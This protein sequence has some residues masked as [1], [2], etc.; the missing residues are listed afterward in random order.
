MYHDILILYLNLR[1]KPWFREEKNCIKIM[2]LC[3]TWACY[4]NGNVSDYYLTN[5]Y[6]WDSSTFQC[7]PKTGTQ[8]KLQT[9]LLLSHF[10]NCVL[11]TY[12]SLPLGQMVYCFQMTSD[13]ITDLV[14][15]LHPHTAICPST[16]LTIVSLVDVKN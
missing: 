11:S 15:S 7:A 6:T 10:H 16:K 3:G 9:V 14:I 4:P 1:H 5:I 12:F 13:K 2:P 8:Q